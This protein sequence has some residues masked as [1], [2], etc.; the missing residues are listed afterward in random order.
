MRTNN[1]P[2]NTLQGALEVG[3]TL[4]S[5]PF[6]RAWYN[7]WGATAEECHKPLPGDELVPKPNIAYTHAIS[8]NAPREAIW[9]WLAQMGQGRGGLYSY[10]GLE[11]M[12]GCEMHSAGRVLPEHQD[13]KVGDQVLFGPAEKKFPGQVVVEIEPGRTLLMV[14]LDPVTRQPVQSATW[15]FHLEEEAEGGTRLLVRGRNGYEPSTANHIMWHIVEPIA[16][17][18]ERRML[19]GLKARAERDGRNVEREN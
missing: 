1:F 19:L 2:A 9:P 11:N 16:F 15:V 14:A 17:V 3:A 10:D 6:S 13:L 5:A 8:I 7:R 4:V 18:M 12:V